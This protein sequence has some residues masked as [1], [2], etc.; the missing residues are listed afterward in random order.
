MDRR[1]DFWEIESLQRN[2]QEKIVLAMRRKVDWFKDFVNAEDG[3]Y[4]DY[5]KYST[6]V[7]IEGERTRQTNYGCEKEK[8]YYC[9]LEGF[10][11]FIYQNSYW[12]SNKIFY[13]DEIKCW[14]VSDRDKKKCVTFEALDTDAQIAFLEKLSYLYNKYPY[15]YKI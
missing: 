11:E 5:P 9:F 15:R 6:I 4:D 8:Y 2:I 10:V 13:N 7:S 3:E 1:K 12:K 14:F